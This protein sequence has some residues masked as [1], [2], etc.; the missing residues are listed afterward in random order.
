MVHGAV[1]AYLRTHQPDEIWLA[2]V[3]APAETCTWALGEPVRGLDLTSWYEGFAPRAEARLRRIAG[4]GSRL[5]YLGCDMLDGFYGDEQLRATAGLLARARQVGLEVV[6]SNFSFN[7]TPSELSQ[8]LMPELVAQGVRFF[9]RDDLSAGRFA[10]IAG[11]R[12]DVAPDVAFRVRPALPDP[13]PPADGVAR[14]GVNLNPWSARWTGRSVHDLA[15]IYA[16]AMSEL[17]AERAVEWF[18]IP[19]DNRRP[20]S[21][22]GALCDLAARLPTAV[23]HEWVEL[24]TA[25]RVKGFCSTLD[26]VITGRMHLAIAALG[27]GVP[28]VVLSYQDKAEG[29]LGAIGME[30]L[31]VSEATVDAI[32]SRVR[33]LLDDPSRAPRLRAL[34]PEVADAALRPFR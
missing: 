20:A 11:T 13:T 9:A 10:E 29:M 12:P 15:A 7:R 27:M 24:T 31:I 4:P 2:A 17:A 5:H 16:S 23:G 26:L 30:D 32:L 33:T 3:D 21:D 14:I 1:D 34:A 25:A 22:R 19:H 18:L 6:V 8:A 28:A